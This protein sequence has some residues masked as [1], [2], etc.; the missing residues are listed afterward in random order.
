MAEISDNTHVKMPGGKYIGFTLGVN[1]VLWLFASLWEQNVAIFV[2]HILLLSCCL[3]GLLFVIRNQIAVRIFILSLGLRSLFAVLAWYFAYNEERKFFIGTNSDASR[4]WDASLLSYDQASLA[5]E[6]P[7]FPRLNVFLTNLSSSISGPHYLATAQS[8]IFAGAMLAVFAYLFVKN[9]YGEKIGRITGYLMALNPIAIAFSTGLMRDELIGMFGFMLLAA[10]SRLLMEKSWFLRLGLFL[11]SI[12]ACIALSFLRSISLAG[13]VVAGFLL[14]ISRTPFR[15]N[16]IRRSTKVAVVTVLSILLIAAVADRFD[17]FEGV[18]SYAVTVRAGEGT[19]DGMELDPNGITTRVAEISPALLS[20]LAP[21]V[22]MQPIPFYA[23]DAPWYA[24]GPPAL[25]DV[26]I[27]IGGLINQLL[28][29]FYVI[30]VRYWFNTQDTVGTRIGMG[31]TMVMC[32]LTLVGLGQVR[33]I[34]AHCYPFFF[35]GVGVVIVNT[36]YGSARRVMIAMVAWISCLTFLYVGYLS[37][38][39]WE[40]KLLSASVFFMS[41]L[42]F[43]L[44]WSMGRRRIKSDESHQWLNRAI[45]PIMRP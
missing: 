19:V 4:F 40:S 27:G 12:G 25:I 1:M 6:D 29:G 39:A 37:Y 23:W 42:S 45:A 43:S 33:M 35:A 31:L 11:V 14:L 44:L 10:L 8:V 26:L 21:T 30:A 3:A 32:A 36:F 5:F 22:L 17:R 41:F 28:F 24:A 38:K 9:I 2:L 20:V 15:A 34:M 18:F 13:F 16:H 7:L